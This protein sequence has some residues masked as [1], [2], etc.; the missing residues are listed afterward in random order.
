MLNAAMLSETPL[1]FGPTDLTYTQG[2]GMSDQFGALMQG[3][4]PLGQAM[5]SNNAQNSQAA[6]QAEMMR[7]Q[8]LQQFHQQM[9]QRRLLAAQ[10]MGQ[11]NAR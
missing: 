10:M 3:I 9:M 8:Q 4:G 11:Q 1:T 5:M 2:Y 7:L 6:Q